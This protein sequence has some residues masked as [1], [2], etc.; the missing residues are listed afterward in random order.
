[1]LINTVILFIKDVLPVFILLC[2]I[3]TLISRDFL[4]KRR[5]S[6][7]A[8][9]TLILV[10][11]IFSRIELISDIFDGGGIEVL[12]SVTNLTLYFCLIFVSVAYI[13]ETRPSNAQGLMLLFVLTV[14]TAVNFS[15]FFLF[16]S[17]LWLN[18]Q[19]ISIILVGSSF[20]LGICISF[21]VL[22][23]LALKAIKV[24]NRFFLFSLWAFYLAGI[25]ANSLYHLQ[26]IDFL[27]SGKQLWDTSH[28]VSDSS[29]YGYL[30]KTLFGY[31]SAPTSK[32]LIIYIVTISISMLIYF[33]LVNQ[34]SKRE[35]LNS[36]GGSL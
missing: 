26:Q 29:E 10:Y 31:T 6:L 35:G 23:E 24:R 2:F 17:T 18:Q 4:S 19:D 3:R 5:S 30:L 13:K 15:E 14:Y 16:F 25:A 36:S 33:I 34:K 12:N 7:Y 27:S 20:G 32:Y 21:S 28:I 11:L 22:F 1:M 9:G 8:I